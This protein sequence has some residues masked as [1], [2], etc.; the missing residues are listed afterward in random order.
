MSISKEYQNKLREK[1]VKKFVLENSRS[2]SP[3]EL[4]FL[5]AS[6]Y[7]E[8]ASVDEIGIS[9]VDVAKPTY[10]ESSSAFTENKNRDAILSD[11]QAIQDR[12]TGVTRLLEDSYRGFQGT[13][14]RT[15]KLLNQVEGKVDNL[16]LLQGD[17]DVF[18][19]GI[20]ESFD[21]QEFV[22]LDKTTA[23]IEAG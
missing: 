6:Y 10:Q 5:L 7:R 15:R 12:I 4:D 19:T 23:S 8:Y 1:A 18:V 16:L 21:T 3:E 13:V 14:N 22:D 17:V 2:P 9:G 20:E 11:L